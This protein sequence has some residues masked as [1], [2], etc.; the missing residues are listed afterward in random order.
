MGAMPS[1][2]IESLFAAADPLSYPARMRLFAERAGELAAAGQLGGVLVELRAGDDFERETGLFL[3]TVA[4]RYEV[5]LSYLDEP[6]W[7]L[8]LRALRVLIRR[9]RIDAAGVAAQWS[10]APAQVRRELSRA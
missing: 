10:D 2:L 4:G 1:P 5:I 7:R 3:S 8:R 9:G 6:D